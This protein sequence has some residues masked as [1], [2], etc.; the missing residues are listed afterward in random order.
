MILD[1]LD[2]IDRMNAVYLSLLL[3]IVL[4]GAVS[5]RREDIS[6]TVRNALVWL[7][8]FAVVV[9]AASFRDDAGALFGRLRGE[10]DPAGGSQT[11]NGEFRIRARDDGHF[12]VRASVNGEAT[13]FLIDTGASDI[14]LTASTARRVGI[15]VANLRHDGV[16]STANGIV[17][18]A[19]STI[20][21]IEIGPI[22]RSD[23]RVSVSGGEL[24]TNLLGMRYLNTL[25]G[26]RVEGQTLILSP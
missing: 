19:S 13:L 16:A 26:W 8:I 12:W 21:L 2:S 4:A 5:I 22:A 7:C 9:L 25:S 11:A 3:L 14:V 24:E 15:D 10:I 18:T 6:R 17:R 23:L 20:R 1:D